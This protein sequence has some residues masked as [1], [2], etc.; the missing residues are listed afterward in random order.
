MM[1]KVKEFDR[2]GAL[3]LEGFVGSGADWLD[4]Y[5]P[6]IED[7]KTIVASPHKAYGPQTNDLVLQLR[8]RNISKIIKRNTVCGKLSHFSA[9]RETTRRFQSP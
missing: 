7:G 2:K 6:F 4:R 1:L 3:T 8:K 9:E 5:K